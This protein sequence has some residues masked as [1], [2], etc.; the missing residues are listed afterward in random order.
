MR[1]EL[2]PL[3]LPASVPGIA[4]LRQAFE[5]LLEQMN[6][7]LAA[8]AREMARTEASAILVEGATSASLPTPSLALRGRS[9]LLMRGTG[10]ADQLY[11]CR[12]NAAEAYEWGLIV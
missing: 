8:V 9:A 11:V 2:Q 6:R 12:K 5:A 10:L 4:G 7:T 1:I 3:T